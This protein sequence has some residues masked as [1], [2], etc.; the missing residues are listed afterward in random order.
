[1]YLRCTWVTS[2][3]LIFPILNHKMIKRIKTN[4]THYQSKERR[5]HTF[6][7]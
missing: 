5:P 2:A 7:K 1:M 3:V 4:T 6:T